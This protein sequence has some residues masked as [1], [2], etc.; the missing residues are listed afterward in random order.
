MGAKTINLI[1][2][3]KMTLLLCA[4]L[5]ANTAFAESPYPKTSVTTDFSDLWWNPAESGWGM[6]LVQQDNV[7][8]ATVFVYATDGNPTWVTA[9]LT[10][11]GGGVFTGPLYATTGPYFG[12]VFNPANVGIRQAGSMTFTALSVQSGTVSYSVDGVSVSKQLQRQTLKADNYNGAYYIALNLT[13]SACSNPA[14][15]GSLTGA[16]GISISQT[17]T[18]MSMVWA[19][20]TNDVC[21]YNGSYSQSGK[22]GRFSGPYSCTTGE[23]GNM[24]FFEMT[25]RIGMLSGRL[26]GQSDTAGCAYTGRFTGIDPSVP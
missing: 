3:G 16:L 11:N 24:T 20:T 18:A 1:G 13:Q 25:N 2:F 10:Y 15:N 21:T 5:F 7:V 26:A 12:G 14:N 4:A 6:Q 22:F 8:F 19:F 17:A 9:Q 23:T